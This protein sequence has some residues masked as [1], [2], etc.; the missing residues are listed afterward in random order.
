MAL[1]RC[2]R[3]GGLVW[4]NAAPGNY[5]KGAANLTRM[6]C[7]RCGSTTHETVLQ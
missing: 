5:S 6:R 3:A 7:T 2:D 4:A 1:V